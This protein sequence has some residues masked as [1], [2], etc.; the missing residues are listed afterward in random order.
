[1][2]A[3]NLEKVL[4]KV[5]EPLISEVHQLAENVIAVALELKHGNK[6]LTNRITGDAFERIKADRDG[7][8]ARLNKAN[9]YFN[10]MK[11]RHPDI[12]WTK[13]G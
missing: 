1:M 10:R 7:L 5:L 9:A 3:A 6:V 8:Q 4:I 12:D 13:E 2:D 11:A